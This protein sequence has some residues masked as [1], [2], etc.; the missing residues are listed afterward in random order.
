MRSLYTPPFYATS[1]HRGSGK[2]LTCCR[3]FIANC[4]VIAPLVMSSS[5]E[6]VRAI[7]I[8]HVVHDEDD[9]DTQFC[10]LPESNKKL[11]ET[12]DDPL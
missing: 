9:N 8:L 12:H 11:K 4:G 10:Q 2:V 3:T 5:S 7:P 1:R 6:S